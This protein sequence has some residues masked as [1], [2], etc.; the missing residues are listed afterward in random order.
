MTNTTQYSTTYFVVRGIVR[1]LV[2]P[3]VMV[4]L[5]LGFFWVIGHPIG[6][7][8]VAAVLWTIVVIQWRRDYRKATAT[9]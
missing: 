1:Y 2:M 8:I 6:A 5:A 3:M 7:L 4:L 9:S